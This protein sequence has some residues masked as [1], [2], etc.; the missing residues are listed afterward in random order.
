MVRLRSSDYV[1]VPKKP[2]KITSTTGKP[3]LKVESEDS[4]S[5][6][7]VPDEFDWSSWQ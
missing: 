6:S 3:V 5:N 1:S 2:P 4:R 7:I